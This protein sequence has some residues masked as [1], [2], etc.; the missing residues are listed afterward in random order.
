[1]IFLARGPAEGLS[2]YLVQNTQ[3]GISL[4]LGPFTIP[5][6]VSLSFG[7]EG[8][9]SEGVGEDCFGLGNDEA[10]DRVDGWLD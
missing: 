5:G 2:E 1:L 6:G 4:P 8:L 9:V 10:G 7:R 3:A